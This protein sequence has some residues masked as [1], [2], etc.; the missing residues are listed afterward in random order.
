MP[1]SFI[2][3]PPDGLGKKS[4][5]WDRGTD[6]HL[7]QFLEAGSRGGKVF[8][9]NTGVISTTVT[10]NLTLWRLANPAG[11]GK[12]L[13]LQKLEITTWCTAATGVVPVFAGRATANPVGGNAV[14][15]ARI[16]DVATAPIAECAPLPNAAVSAANFGSYSL[17]AVVANPQGPYPLW[18]SKGTDQDLAIAVT[19]GIIIVCSGTPSAAHRFIVNAVWEEV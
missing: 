4:L 11:T 13:Y 10:A 19:T 1:K 15:A 16:S 2:Q 14:T 9:A 5:T 7:E 18:E 3:L 8:A 12:V 17:P 6:G